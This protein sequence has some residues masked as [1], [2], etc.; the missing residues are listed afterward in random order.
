MTEQT[1]KRKA[2][3]V[4]AYGCEPFRGSEAGVGWNWVIQMARSCDLHVIVR[5]NDRAKIEANVPDGARG[6]LN[7]YYFDCGPL[8]RSLKN[9]EKGLYFYYLCW[10]LGIVKVARGILRRHKIDYTMHLTFGSFWMPTFLPLLS[11][12]FIWGPMGGGDAV[13][14][15]LLRSLPPRQRIV[16]GTRVLLDK[17]AF[18]NPMIRIPS[19]R[20]VHIL[21]RTENN[22]MVIPRVHRSKAVVVLET[23]IEDEVLGEYITDAHVD[24]EVRVI[25]SG[26]LVP[27]KNVG[28]AIRAF[29]QARGRIGHGQLTIIGDGPERSSLMALADR[30][31]IAQSV[32]FEGHLPRERVL[33]QLC[34][35]DIFLFPSLREGGSW[36]LME[37]MAVGLPVVCLDWTGMHVIVD[38]HSAV[39]IRPSSYERTTNDMA[40]A[41]VMLMIDDEKRTELGTH[42]R[43]RVLERFNWS[44]KGEFFQRLVY[45]EELVDEGDA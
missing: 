39:L 10:Q 45:S 34:A 28:M 19:E 44:A 22:L 31:G 12:P 23:A 36:S 8:L 38:E 1:R 32:R 21:C 27:F 7:F 4:S 40:Q 25:V 9:K 3:L 14:L 18:L 2:I 16:Q 24:R 26:R 15:S 5:A 17:T 11:R 43:H 37:G 35:A 41:L 6:H 13:P 20:A 30:L 42:A 29:A 33:E